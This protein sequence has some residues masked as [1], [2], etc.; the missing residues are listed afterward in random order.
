MKYMLFMLLLAACGS[1]DFSLANE[2]GC[3]T[4]DSIA[5]DDCGVGVYKRT[6]CSIPLGEP[7][8]GSGCHSPGNKE[9]STVWCC[10]NG[11]KEPDAGIDIK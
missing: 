6:Q 11:A 2:S 4:H 5:G 1:N 3:D 10:S 8:N 7:W 9:I